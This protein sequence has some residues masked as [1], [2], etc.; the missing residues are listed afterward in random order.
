MQPGLF[1]DAPRSNLLIFEQ[2]RMEQMLFSLDI[3]RTFQRARILTFSASV[4]MIHRLAEIFDDLE[5]IFGYERP[6]RDNVELWAMQKAIADGLLDEFRRLADRRQEMLAERL[7]AGTLRFLL[8]K[9]DLFSC[10]GISAGGG[11]TGRASG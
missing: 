2:M 7:R 8:L 11:A 6:A 1:Q 10:Q 4:S 3:L 9:K 5:I